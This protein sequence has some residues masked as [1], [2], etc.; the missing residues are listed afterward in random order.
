MGATRIPSY[1][2]TVKSEAKMTVSFL[3][4]NLKLQ[5]DNKNNKKKKNGYL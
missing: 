1:R 4:Q 5:Q 3:K 2:K